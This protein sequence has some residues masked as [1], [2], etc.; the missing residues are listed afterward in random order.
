MRWGNNN[1]DRIQKHPVR[2]LWAV[3]SPSNIEE[4]DAWVKEFF[5]SIDEIP[6]RTLGP[7]L[8]P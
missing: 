3:I 1:E 2:I 5:G 6:R 4:I 7:S 8:V